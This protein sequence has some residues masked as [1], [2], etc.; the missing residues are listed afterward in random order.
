MR[1]CRLRKSRDI[2]CATFRIT[3]D[4]CAVPPRDGTGRITMDVQFLPDVEIT[5]P[6]CGGLRYAKAAGKIR[7]I[8]SEG[9]EGLSLPEL[10]SLTIDQ[11]IEKTADLKKVRQRLEI[12][13]ELGL[14][15]LTLGEATPALSGGEAQRLK[16]AAE[17]GR[18]QEDTVFVFDEPTV[19]T[20]SSGCPVTDRHFSE[21][22]RQRSHRHRHRTQSG[23]DRQRG[24]CDR[25][26]TRRRKGRRTDRRL[27]YAG[28]YRTG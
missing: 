4:R 2:P 9:E 20:S 3:R 24:L 15:Y 26:G 22:D 17:I 14:G 23:Y 21:T 13:S 11:A 28:G 18:V 12:L 27:R 5:C 8:P 10:M 6:E 1:L 7:R 19:W 25:H 16:L